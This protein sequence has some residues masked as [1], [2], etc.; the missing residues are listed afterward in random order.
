MAVGDPIVVAARPED[1]TV[2]AEAAV[3]IPV[4]VTS[5]EFHGHAFLCGGIGSGG[6]EVW[7]RSRRRLALGAEARL[8][9]DAGKALVFPTREP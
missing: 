6:A 8:G 5:C 1:M 2:D 3:S 4:T 7:F 9:V